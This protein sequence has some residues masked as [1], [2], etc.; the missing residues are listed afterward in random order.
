[1]RHMVP[2]L[3]ALVASGCAEAVY[4]SFGDFDGDY[5]LSVEKNGMAQSRGAEEDAYPLSCSP[6]SESHDPNGVHDLGDNP[7]FEGWYY[8]MTDPFTQ[9][10]WVFIAAYWV[11]D[12]HRTRA[13]IELIQSET[14]AVYKQVFEDVDLGMIQDQAGSVDLQFGQMRFTPNQIA[15]SMETDEGET[16]SLRLDID[17]C[18]R[19]GAPEDASNRWTMGWATEFPQIPLRWHVHHLKAFA[20]GYIQ[21]PEGSWDVEDYPLHQEKNWGRA[22]PTEWYWF[23]SNHFEGRPDVAFAAASGPIWS[24]ALAPTGFMAGL[25]W[26][27]EFFTWRTQDT[28][29][30]ALSWFWVDEEAGEARW[31]LIGDS[32]RY[33]VDVE[34]W[35]PV[36][37]LIAIDIPTV[38]GL[39][40][41]AVEHL[42]ADMKI[43]IYERTLFGWEHIDTVHSSS[44]AVEAGGEAATRNGLLPETLK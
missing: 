19:W 27:D 38:D 29:S 25:R 37:E 35:A 26:N 40:P 16:V 28:H 42:S 17:G 23:Q 32:R 12:D 7:Q 1:M 2:L 11:D 5:V 6:L 44:A 30:L 31:H 43:S 15:G 18:A 20:S 39:V 8:R 9:E 3:L 33:R 22:F 21:T 4:E 41:G 36:D 24:N 34:V 14:G 13:F 10:S